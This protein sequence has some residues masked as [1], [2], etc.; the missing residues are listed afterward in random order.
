MTLT[1]DNAGGSGGIIRAGGGGDFTL[2]GGA[3]KHAMLQRRRRAGQI[4]FGIP[5][6]T[7]QGVSDTRVGQH[8]LGFD[9]L[10]GQTQRRSVGMQQAGIGDEFHPGGFGGVND[11]AVLYSTLAD[12][13]GGD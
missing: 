7:Q 2:A 4:V 10:C 11:V 13:A 3:D 9:M 5:A 12:F 6:V 1:G 8:L